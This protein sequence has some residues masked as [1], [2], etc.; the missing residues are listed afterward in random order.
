MYRIIALL[1]LQLLLPYVAAIADF[2]IPYAYADGDGDGEGESDSDGGGDSDG[3]SDG[4]DSSSEGSS[5]G[6][7]SSGDNSGASPDSSSSSE[8]ESGDSE[9]S[10]NSDNRQRNS[11]GHGRGKSHQKSIR[12]AVQR[13]QILPLNQIKRLIRKHTRSEIISIEL[14]KK[15]FG[16]VYEFKIVDRSGHLLDIYMDAKTGKIL[17]SKSLGKR[18]N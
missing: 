6:D 10:G 4:G 12:N 1:L 15:R 14:E 18:D 17:K 9:K 11:K 2:S 13:N 16:W 7:N 3:G 5:S 8:S